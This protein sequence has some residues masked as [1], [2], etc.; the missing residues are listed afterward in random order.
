[1]LKKIG[2][3]PEHIVVLL[4]GVNL[5]LALFSSRWAEAIAWASAAI[6]WH[7]AGSYRKIAEEMEELNDRALTALKS[8]RGHLESLRNEE[9][10]GDGK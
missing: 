9:E 8:A 2:L 5:G 3:F 4:C 7:G 10:R 1:M 6:G